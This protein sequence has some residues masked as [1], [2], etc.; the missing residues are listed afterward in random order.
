MTKPSAKVK[1]RR[2]WVSRSEFADQY[3]NPAWQ[4]RRLER[5][6]AAAWECENCGDKEAQLHVHHVRYVAG[7]KVW[8]YG[9]DELAAAA[10]NQLDGERNQGPLT[11]STFEECAGAADYFDVEWQELLE[12]HAQGQLTARRIID[13]KLG[14]AQAVAN[15][16][17]IKRFE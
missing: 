16:S 2:E 4:K 5:L 1:Q 10:T 12:I 14:K 9:D 11:F 8:E 13:L 3:K 17:R 6:D 7:R 15:A